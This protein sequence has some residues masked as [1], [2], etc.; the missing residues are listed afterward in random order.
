M[1]MEELDLIEQLGCQLAAS[2][3]YYEADPEKWYEPAV[4]VLNRAGAFLVA[5][6]RALPGDYQSIFRRRSL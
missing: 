2:L 3:E 4:D 6:G 1:S 5:N